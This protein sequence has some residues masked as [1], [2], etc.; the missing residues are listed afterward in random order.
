MI[1]EQSGWDTELDHIHNTTEETS[2]GDSDSPSSLCFVHNKSKGPALTSKLL[3]R[4][5]HLSDF[6]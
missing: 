1:R 4:T 2:G 5:Q 3:L 6:L